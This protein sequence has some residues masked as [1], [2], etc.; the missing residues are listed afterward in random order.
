MQENGSPSSEVHSERASGGGSQSPGALSIVPRG[1]EYASPQERLSSSTRSSEAAQ[2]GD[3]L[4]S[5]QVQAQV[6][7]LSIYLSLLNWALVHLHQLVQVPQWS[8][9]LLLDVFHAP[10]SWSCA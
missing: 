2:S 4:Y 7:C 6:G 3:S 5:A 1:S 8:N 10:E 9:L